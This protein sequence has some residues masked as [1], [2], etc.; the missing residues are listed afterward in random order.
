MQLLNKSFGGSVHAKAHRQDGQQEIELETSC[1]L[2]AGLAS[3]EQVLLTHGD[4]IDQPAAG[5]DIVAK[6]GDIIAGRTLH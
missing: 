2:F 1:S 3:R 5:Y 6:A 4:S